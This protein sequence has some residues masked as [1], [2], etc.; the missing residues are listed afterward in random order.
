MLDRLSKEAPVWILDPVD[1]TLMFAKGDEGFA[2]IVALA[3]KGRTVAGWIHAP[4][5]NRTVVAE[6]GGGAWLDGQRSHVS[7]DGPIAEMSGSVWSL[8]AGAARLKGKVRNSA[9][10]GSAGR[11]YMALAEGKLDFVMCRKL[12]PWDHAAGVLIHAEAGGT[13]ALFDGAPYRPIPIVSP[14]LLAPGPKSWAELRAL[15]AD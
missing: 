8:A 11:A 9:S 12:N 15:A 5:P 14:M 6:E 4:V 10:W 1:G 3:V 7:A 2:V 13:S